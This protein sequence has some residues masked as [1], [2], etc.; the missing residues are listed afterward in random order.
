MFAGYDRAEAPAVTDRYLRTVFEH[1]GN[2]CCWYCDGRVEPRVCEPYASEDAPDDPVPRYDGLSLVRY[3]CRRCGV[4]VTGDLGSAL[5]NRPP[6]VAFHCDH[7]VDVRER[8][9]WQFSA[10]NTDR[11]EVRERDPLRAAAGYETGGER[12]T[13][14]ADEHP[15]VVATTREA[16]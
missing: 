3:A 4:E 9:Y 8:E 12:L 15:D 1:V 10:M 6:M 2:G 7:G 11:A 5:L 14:R 16:V 13:L